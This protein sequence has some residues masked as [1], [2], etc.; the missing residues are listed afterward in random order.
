MVNS[1]I[2][3]KTGL[4]IHY[5]TIYGNDVSIYALDD[6]VRDGTDI[7]HKEGLEEL[8]KDFE[9]HIQSFCEDNYIT[10]ENINIDSLFEHIEEE[11]NNN[12]QCDYQVYHYEKDGYHLIYNNDD[13]SIIILKSPYVC[14]AAQCSPCFLNGGYIKDKGSVLTYCLGHDF[15]DE[16]KP[17]QNEILKLED[18]INKED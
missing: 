12:Y 13:N 6:I 2:D 4:E 16:D 18:L 9:S 3:E 1:I 11:F 15:Y 7:I 14:Y 5:G 10:F 8:K 17:Y